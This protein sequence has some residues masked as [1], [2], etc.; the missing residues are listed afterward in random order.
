VSASTDREQAR[1]SPQTSETG[2]GTLSSD[3]EV[4]TGP[5][6]SGSTVTTSQDAATSTTRTSVPVATSVTTTS[7][8]VTTETTRPDQVDQTF[9]LIGGRTAIRFSPSEIVVLWMAPA[10]GFVPSSH[11]D[12]GGVEVMFSNG[13]HR[14]KLEAWWDDGPRFYTEEEEDD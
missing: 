10:D 6:S 5:T 4:A 11:P 8:P 12:D 13:R 3:E 2:R 1:S 9:D 7:R 14:S